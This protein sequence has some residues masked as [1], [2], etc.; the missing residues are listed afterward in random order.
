MS[1]VDVPVTVHRFAPVAEGTQAIVLV[2]RD[3][4]GPFAALLAVDRRYRAIPQTSGAV[5]E[6]AAMAHQLAAAAI[7]A[8]ADAPDQLAAVAAVKLTIAAGARWYIGPTDS[9]PGIIGDQVAIVRASSVDLLHRAAGWASDR[10]VA[11]V[12]LA[13]RS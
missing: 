4:D 11:S 7:L 1:P 8:C 3:V 13:V 5:V 12:E 10:L 2:G 6:L 9:R